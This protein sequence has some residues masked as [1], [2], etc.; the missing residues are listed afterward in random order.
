MILSKIT[1]KGISYYSLHAELAF[2]KADNRLSVQIDRTYLYGA[3]INDICE[4]ILLDTE[5]SIF[6]LDFDGI[7]NGQFN[8]LD[9]KIQELRSHNKEIVFVGVKDSMIKFDSQFDTEK[10]IAKGFEGQPIDTVFKEIFKDRLKQYC[11]KDDNLNHSSSVMVTAYI[12]IKEF[13]TKEKRFAL[14]CIYQLA[15]QIRKKEIWKSYLEP[16]CKNKPVLIC[17][18]LNGSFIASVLSMLL[19]L[20]LF[21]FDSIGPI[22]K[23]YRNLGT[24]IELTKP[25]L[26]VSDVVCLG[27]E[28]KITKNIVEYLGGVYLGNVSIVRIE[29]IKPY[30]NTESVYIINKN[31]KNE[32]NYK[33]K[34]ALDI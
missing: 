7:E 4:D 30:E 12:D 18:S 10:K 19:G 8:V 17:Q 20:D 23:L 25:Y 22:N 34:T 9:E 3:I 1:H 2:L 15:R 32:F 31:N 14:F 24:T 13:F 33:I 29:S 6:V 5:S 27:T 28:V 21:I 16:D 26:I 11:R